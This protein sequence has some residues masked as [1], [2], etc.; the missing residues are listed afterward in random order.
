[1][2]TS[3][4]VRKSDIKEYRYFAEYGGYLPVVRGNR[5]DEIRGEWLFPHDYPITGDYELPQNPEDADRRIKERTHNERLSA[6]GK[7]TLGIVM[8]PITIPLI[9][10]GEPFYHYYYE[11]KDRRRREELF[12]QTAGVDVSITVLDHQGRPVPNAMIREDYSISSFFCCSYSHS[13]KNGHRSFRPAFLQSYLPAENFYQDVARHLPIEFGTSMRCGWRGGSWPIGLK[14]HYAFDHSTDSTGRA[15]YTS[16][17]YDRYAEY[18]DATW[19]WKETAP[20][21]TYT[22][23]IWAPGF[24]PSVL[25]V[26][27]VQPLRKIDLSIL[28]DP[29]PEYDQ[30]NQLVKEFMALRDEFVE[31][32]AFLDDTRLNE[33]ITRLQ[34]W[35]EDERLPKYF[36]L[37][38]LELLRSIQK[39][40]STDLT[41]FFQGF[42]GTAPSLSP[43]LV[44]GPRNPWK[45]RKEYQ[46]WDERM[47]KLCY[48]ASDPKMVISSLIGEARQ[49]L[50]EGEEIDPGIPQLESLRAVI[51]FADGRRQNAVANSKYMEHCKYFGLFY[52]DIVFPH[53]SAKISDK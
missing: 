24:R 12:K 33:I 31:Q 7:T 41:A 19:Q 37:N 45:F 36:R 2:W 18:K 11:P 5:V 32:C 29:L 26:E 1:M 30:V 49:L 34:T 53:S 21:V 42:A 50:P 13:D 20:I 16:S 23:I 35:A 47:D 9:L 15:R 4:P 3:N 8:L 46:K 38:S 10:I 25:A 6:V 44:D 43:Y 14:I 17:F 48:G 22:F 40:T 51:D 39:K 28:L 52:P 27:N